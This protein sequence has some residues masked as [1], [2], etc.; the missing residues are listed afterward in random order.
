[1]TEK[2]EKPT[3]RGVE[4]CGAPH[5][6]HPDITCERAAGHIWIGHHMAARLEQETSPIYTWRVR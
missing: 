3:V 6:D 5:P 2:P 4:L 1:M